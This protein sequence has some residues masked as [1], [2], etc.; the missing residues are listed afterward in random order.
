[1]SNLCTGCN[2]CADP[3]P[4]HCISLRNRSQKHLTPGNGI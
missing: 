4:T 2:L 3:C 1:M